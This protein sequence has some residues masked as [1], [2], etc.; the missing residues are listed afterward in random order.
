[1]EPPLAD[2][3]VLTTGE[4]A[5]ALKAMSDPTRLLILK[6]LFKGEKCGTELAR[7]LGLTQPH[8][9][10]HLS[11]LKKARLVDSRR[12]GKMVC[13]S[14][15]RCVYEAMLETETN[16]IDLGCCSMTFNKE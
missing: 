15:H 3:P 6:T 11:V 12:D 7:E 1:M 14:L 16:T 5:L 4:C 10:H 13:Y 9:A 8:I 2:K